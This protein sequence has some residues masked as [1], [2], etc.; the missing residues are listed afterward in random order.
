MNGS[1]R[2]GPPVVLAA[3]RLRGQGLSN[4]DQGFRGRCAD[5][6]AR[7]IVLSKGD[8]RPILE[9]MVRSLGSGSRRGNA[10]LHFKSVRFIGQLDECFWSFLF[11]GKAYRWS[12]LKRWCAACPSSPVSD[13]QNGPGKMLA[14]VGTAGS[15]RWRTTKPSRRPCGEALTWTETKFLSRRG[16]RQDLLDAIVDES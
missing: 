13:C 6:M 4:L 10:R 3:G 5:Q 14:E 15:Y 16:H 11:G 1:S 8:D 12:S 9:R 7:L 2:L